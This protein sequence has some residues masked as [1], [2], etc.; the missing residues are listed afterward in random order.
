MLFKASYIHASGS[1]QVQ[2][3]EPHDP[4]ELY[5]NR[6]GMKSISHRG[7]GILRANA[8]TEFFFVK[9]INF[10]TSMDK[11]SVKW[12]DLSVPKIQHTVEAWEWISNLFPHFARN[13]ISYRS[14]D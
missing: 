12:N 8:K 4:I 11:W 13:V 10:N 7:I 6:D 5:T 1:L 3:R 2:T 14:W 9:W